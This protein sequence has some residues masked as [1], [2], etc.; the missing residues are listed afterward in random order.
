MNSLRKLAS[1]LELSHATVSAALRGLPGVKAG[2]RDRVLRAAEQCGYR[3]NPLASALMASMRRVEKTTFRGV[4]VL[5][6]PAVSRVV[7]DDSEDRDR[8]RIASGAADRARELGF[9]LQEMQVGRDGNVPEKLHDILR[10]RGVLGVVMLAAPGE[11]ED[12]RRIDR[13]IIPC[14][15]AG[16][17]M[18]GLD[19]VGPD[20]EE[21][22]ALALRQLRAAGCARVGLA[23]DRA[24]STEHHRT[25][26]AG[27][28][29]DQIAEAGAPATGG[30]S[31]LLI[32]DRSGDEPFRGWLEAGRYDAVIADAQLPLSWQHHLRASLGGPGVCQLN[33]HAPRERDPGVDLRW[34]MIGRKS[35]ELLAD[36]IL[37]RKTGRGS[38]STTTTLCHPC[39]LGV[40]EATKLV[41]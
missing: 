7:R 24:G 35:V 18:D 28:F 21:A 36:H 4:L 23:L 37:L 22:M 40:A 31:S 14:V 41:A 1:H 6:R 19:F 29:A 16:S 38:Q 13:G 17:R 27:F 11:G 9:D 10:A 15:C 8:R 20:H 30:V 32:Y 33:L 34:E 3:I 39:W 25:W 12:W 26:I 5:L 2:T